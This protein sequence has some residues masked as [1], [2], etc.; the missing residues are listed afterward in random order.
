MNFSYLITNTV[1]GKRYVGITSTSIERRWKR[2]CADCKQPKTRL[3]R[4]MNKHGIGAFTIN[5]LGAYETWQDACNA[6]RIFIQKLGTFGDNGY[7]MTQGGD[8]ALGYRFSDDKKKK[9]A[10]FGIDNPF[11]GRKHSDEVKH[12]MSESHKRTK[13][14]E[15]NVEKQKQRAIKMSLNNMGRKHSA[16]SRKHM[17]EGHKVPIKQLTLEGE[18]LGTFPSAL[19]VERSLGIKRQYVNRC[20]RNKRKKAGGFIWRYVNQERMKPI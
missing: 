4:S 3:H 18:M 11:Y 15:E 5:E 1:T 9:F 14:S 10:R 16:E 6:E 13:L 7:N 20:C 17:G 8:G 19:D 2:H 12:Q